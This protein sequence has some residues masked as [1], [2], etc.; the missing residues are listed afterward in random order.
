MPSSHH[1]RLHHR[2]VDLA[3]VAGDMR[4]RASGASVEMRDWGTM[5]HCRA[6]FVVQQAGVPPTSFLG[7][8]HQHPAALTEPTTSERQME[9]TATR[10]SHT[11]SNRSGF[12]PERMASGLGSKWALGSMESLVKL[13]AKWTSGAEEEERRSAEEKKRNGGVMAL[14]RWCGRREH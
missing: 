3:K 9:R 2:H 12:R 11:I 8:K 7:A 4:Q 1:L 6:P 13:S 10:Q 5:Y 14:D